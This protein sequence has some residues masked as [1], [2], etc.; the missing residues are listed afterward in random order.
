[1]HT[2]LHTRVKE[3]DEWWFTSLQGISTLL[4]WSRKRNIQMYTQTLFPVLN[5]RY[6]TS[7][8]SVSITVVHFP[9][10]ISSIQNVCLRKNIQ[11]ISKVREYKLNSLKRNLHDQQC[12]LR[13]QMSASDYVT[14]ATLKIS[15]DFVKKNHRNHIQMATLLQSVLK[16]SSFFVCWV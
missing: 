16:M 3:K 15:L 14:E 6:R 7:Y 12:I 11:L 5:H 8:I 4:D 2:L 10:R 1:M 9:L 13:R